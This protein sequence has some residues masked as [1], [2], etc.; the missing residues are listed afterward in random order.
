MACHFFVDSGK[1]LDRPTINE[2]K[3]KI[4]CNLRFGP[5]TTKD[6]EWIAQSFLH[7]LRIHPYT[8]LLNPFAMSQFL[9]VLFN[10]TH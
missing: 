8:L 7:N 1:F 10:V 3:G 4:W 5:K 6:S 2:F 9:G